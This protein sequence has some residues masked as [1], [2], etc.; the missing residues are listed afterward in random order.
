M[1]FPRYLQAIS[2]RLRKLGNAG[3][4]RDEQATQQ[5]AE[6]WSRYQ[7]RHERHRLHGIH[8]PALEQYRWMIE[9][10]RVSLFAQELRTSLPVSSKRME[11]QWVL[12]KS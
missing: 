3:L 6:Y 10:L 1:H 2:H 11:A 8:D 7:A 4:S 5:V 12:V 9:E